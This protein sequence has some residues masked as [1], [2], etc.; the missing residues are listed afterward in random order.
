VR[1]DAFDVQ[2]MRLLRPQ[3]IVLSPGPCTP[4]QAA[5]SIEFVRECYQ[6]VPILG[7][8]LG[9]Q[10]IAEALGGKTI[11]AKEPVQGR[12]CPIAHN[13]QGIFRGL[14]NPLIVGRYHSLVVERSSLPLEI[15]VTAWTA[16]GTVM[17]IAHRNLPVVGL[18]FHPESILTLSGYD[19][20]AAF[21]RMAGAQ[22]PVA[23]P[24]IDDEC[25]AGAIAT[26]QCK[27]AG[28]AE[29]LAVDNH[30]PHK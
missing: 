22:L 9:H 28:A 8:C 1:N 3:G 23:I 27:P 29:P 13:N 2:H 4:Q 25:H 26:P 17:A 6:S 18:Q 14:P 5:S 19:L 15:E 10:I 12:A 11:P 16:D 21:L 7:V 24:T 30:D 20:L